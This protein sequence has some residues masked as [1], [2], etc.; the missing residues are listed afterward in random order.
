MSDLGSKLSK[1]GDMF[2]IR[3]AEPIMIDGKIIVAAGAT[4]MGEVIFAKGSGGSG[5]AG[6]LVLA[7]RYVD[8]G[9]KRV[10]LRSLQLNA[11]GKSRIN[12]A[13]AVAIG[14]GSI[15]ALFIRGKQS[16]VPS[17]T[18]ADA[19]I[20]EDIS[21]TPD[22]IAAAAVVAAAPPPTSNAQGV[23]ASQPAAA[24]GT[25]PISQQKGKTS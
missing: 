3:L 10:R 5:A 1:T 19:K 18:V 21:F 20:A 7:A 4:G 13:D 16:V 6:E 25:Q 9:S 22:E 15:V 23:P 12:T 14:G 2:P 17:G 11:V 24:S 8:A